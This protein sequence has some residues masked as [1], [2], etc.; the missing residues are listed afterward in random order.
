MWHSIKVSQFGF[1]KN[2]IYAAFELLHKLEGQLPMKS[3]RLS[4]SAD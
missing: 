3:A 1:G 2:V 4:N